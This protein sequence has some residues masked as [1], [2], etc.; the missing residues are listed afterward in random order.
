MNLLR[1]IILR[2]L[3]LAVF[4]ALFA[5]CLYCW[6]APEKDAGELTE[7]QHS[8]D[9][10]RQFCRR[11][12]LQIRQTQQELNVLPFFRADLRIVKTA[13]LRSQELLYDEAQTRYYA[14]KNTLENAR[15]GMA[16]RSG[17]YWRKYLIPALWAGISALIL[18]PVLLK[19]L[20]YCLVAPLVEIC[21]PAKRAPEEDE[22]EKA[23]QFTPGAAVLDVTLEPGTSLFLR[24]GDWGKK[25]SGVLAGTRFMWSWKYPLVSFAAGLCELVEMIPEDG[26]TGTVTVASPE[27]DFF[28]A[29]I[30]LNGTGVVIRPRFLAGFSGEVKI[31]TRWSFHPHDLL[32]GRIRQIIL[33]GSGSLLVT[34]AWGVEEAVPA[35]GQDWRIEDGLLLGY[36]TGAEYSLCRTETFWHYFRGQTTLFDRR[37]RRGIF[38]TQNN[39][40]DFRKN[41]G[42]F[43]ER[44]AN[45]LLNGIGGLLGF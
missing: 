18:L 3:M 30:D 1:A 27:P 15:A 4:A 32:S 26:K 35:E 43:L 19:I 20:L 7:M 29:K 31:R 11:L 33:S 38:F 45:A 28:V 2:L 22:K 25:R 42:T 6:D 13:E 23:L 36:S 10:H 34:G 8:L 21:P 9:L 41:G 39:R 37:I 16:D 5:V 12:Y 14:A 24:S 17:D 40:Q 44:T